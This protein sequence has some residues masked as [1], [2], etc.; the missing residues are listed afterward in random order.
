MD[1]V[2]WTYP[3]EVGLIKISCYKDSLITMIASHYSVFVNFFI[4]FPFRRQLRL[5]E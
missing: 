4:P 5:S 1:D 2:I 3:Y